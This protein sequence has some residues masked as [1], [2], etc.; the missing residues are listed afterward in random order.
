VALRLVFFACGVA[1]FGLIVWHLPLLK[2]ATG[3]VAQTICSKGFIS[4]IAQE[5]VMRD[6]LLPQPGMRLIAW[7]MTIE[8]DR[9]SR[10]VRAR[11]FGGFES[12]SVYRTG[13]GC[14]LA[15]PGVTEPTALS[16][17]PVIAPVLPQIGGQD[18]AGPLDPR[19]RA[20]LDN[21]FTEPGFGAPR[22]TQAIV[23][24]HGGGI[25]AERYAPGLGPDT[26]LLSHSLA[27]SVVNALVG[28]LVRNGKLRVE[29]PA[30]IAEWRGDARNK[31]TI[32]ELLQMTAG[33]GFD[34]GGGPNISSRIWYTEPDMASAAATSKPIAKPGA[35]W[36][37]CSRCYILLSRIIGQA[38]GGGPQGVRDFAQR[39]LFGP[40][41][42][43]SVTLEFDASGTLMGANALYA[44]PRDFARFGLLYLKEGVVGGRRI[45]PENWVPYSTR[46]YQNTGYG[47]GFWLNNTDT[48][49]PEW[50]MTWGLPG[51]PRD[52]YMARG[53]LGQYIVIVP[54]ADLVIV[55]MG[56]S[57]TRAME[58]ASVGA[59]V[60]EIVATL[61]LL[62]SK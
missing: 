59:L 16:P 36:G 62:A 41:G 18:I 58:A 39:E 48:P 34:E 60:R 7:A 37:Y 30:P 35:S 29:E 46:P 49:L 9:A 15:Y 47:A 23:V 38:V 21:A 43:N 42:M 8:T 4:G 5:N 26:P 52:S 54:S 57:H 50:D 2:E 12:R 3:S 45:L 44:T 31:I 40:L 13:R 17:A 11:V 22:N 61:P 14:A 56:Q 6:H 10:E 51:A 20:A 55:R 33:F 1:L 32:S 25:I 53:Y 27:K 28:I 19:L 24:V